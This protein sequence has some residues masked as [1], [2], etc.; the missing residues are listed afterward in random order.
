[1]EYKKYFLPIVTLLLVIGFIC[2][3][4]K[5]FIY[6]IISL[7]LALLGMPIMNFITRLR[8][9]KIKI[10][11]G[12]SAILTLGIFFAV[13]Y[14]LSITFLPPLINQITFLS[15]SNLHDIIYN[16]SIYYPNIKKTIVEFGSEKQLMQIINAQLSQ[17]VNFRNVTYIFNNTLSYFGIILGGLFSVLFIT[18]FFLKDDKLVIKSLLL[19]TPSTFESEMIDIYRTSKKMLS[20][21]FIG[22]FIDVAFITITV[23]SLFYLFGMQ[24][25]LVI[26]CLAGIMNIIPY[27]GPIITLIFAIIFG[28][29]GCIELNQYELISTTITKTL[30]ILIGTNLIDAMIIQPTIFSNTVKAH[31][32]EIFLVVLMASALGG[33]IGMIVAIPTYTLLRIIAKEFFSHLKFFK[34]LTENIPE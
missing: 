5:I 19:I 7:I 23:T 25:A 14:I 11:N 13:I 20:N 10:N 24:N 18:F 12:I 22:L 27:I 8:I 34:K 32:L 3:F 33:V 4:T 28:I 21:Y 9:G 1:M 29:S 31:P 2:A 26:G 30:I 15:S 6:L 16:F 17:F